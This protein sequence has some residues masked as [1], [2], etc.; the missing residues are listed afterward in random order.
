DAVDFVNVVDHITGPDHIEPFSV[1]QENLQLLAVLQ[2]ANELE[3]KG[4]CSGHRR[5]PAPV[6]RKTA[7]APRQSARRCQRTP[8]SL[9]RDECSSRPRQ[10][11]GHADT[12]GQLG[13][14]DAF[15]LKVHILDHHRWQLGQQRV[16][17]AAQLRVAAPYR[18]QDLITR[19]LGFRVD[20]QG[21]LAARQ[22]DFFLAGHGVDA[23]DGRR[24]VQLGRQCAMEFVQLLLGH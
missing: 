13:V 11:K 3:R 18:K 23:V 5:D 17:K 8:A 15:T 22:V 2:L 7:R 12:P 20:A 21:V 19:Q 4:R 24:G 10:V 16:Q 9:L 14:G 1:L 6:R